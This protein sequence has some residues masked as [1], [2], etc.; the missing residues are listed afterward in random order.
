MK[1]LRQ[2]LGLCAATTCRLASCPVVDLSV[3][4]YCGYTNGLDHVGFDG[5]LQNFAGTD[6]GQDH[7]FGMDQSNLRLERF[8]G[9]AG[10]AADLRLCVA[11][12]QILR[13]DSTGLIQVE[14]CF[15]ASRRRRVSCQLPGE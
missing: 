3:V 1:F 15:L 11:R 14:G 9:A 13:V 10:I 5:R 8:L 4:L 12:T 6:H 2:L 7:G